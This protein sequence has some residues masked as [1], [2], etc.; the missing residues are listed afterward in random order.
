MKNKFEEAPNLQ[1]IPSSQMDIYQNVVNVLRRV[2]DRVDP[3]VVSVLDRVW[4]DISNE[5]IKRVHDGLSSVPHDYLNS[6]LTNEDKTPNPDAHL[7]VRHKLH[8]VNFKRRK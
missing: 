2:Y 1:H 4:K 7:V 3:N 6:G 8:V 5:Q